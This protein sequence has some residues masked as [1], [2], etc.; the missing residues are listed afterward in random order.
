[1]EIMQEENSD[2]EPR[3]VYNRI[4]YLNT[5]NCRE[6]RLR[7]RLTKLQFN[8][9]LVQIEDEIVQT[10]INNAVTPTIQLL[11]ALRFY[12]TGCFL[13]VV[14]DFCGISTKTAQRIV[15][16]IFEVI[17]RKLFPL[18]VKLPRGEAHQVRT[19]SQN[20]KI[21]GMPR[22]IGAIDC[23]HVRIKSYGGEDAELW[24]NRKGYFS[25]NV[26]CL[27]NSDL[28][29]MDV[30]ARWPGST[31]DSTIFANSRLKHRFDHY[32]CGNGLIL[33]D[34]GYC[35]QRY[36]MTPLANPNTPAEVLYNEAHIRTRCMKRSQKIDWF[37]SNLQHQDSDEFQVSGNLRDE[38]LKILAQET[39]Q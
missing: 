11:V 39:S 27:V 26:Q 29:L 35:N 1:M 15:H 28:E 2:R 36:L 13:Q 17:A 8:E 7:F 19:M 30:V 4:N 6:F 24:R 12:A 10:D 31:H 20:F 22:V 38:D 25:I 9:V 16:R 3:M 32:E 14:G 18:Y 33:G 23:V 34:R 37:Y 21:S 5:L